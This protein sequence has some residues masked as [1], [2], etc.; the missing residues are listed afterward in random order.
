MSDPSRY[1]VFIDS[2][3]KGISQY[4]NVIAGS[5]FDI[6]KSETGFITKSIDPK[7]DELLSRKIEQLDDIQKKED[8]DN[9]TKLKL[10][11]KILQDFAPSIISNNNLEIRRSGANI[12]NGFFDAAKQTED[13]ELLKTASTIS[14]AVKKSVNNLSNISSGVVA[15]AV[16]S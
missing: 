10:T 5:F 15:S 1:N 14:T 4:I 7:D 11:G 9:Y 16:K 13:D 3:N 8:Y 6:L 12:I 2:Y